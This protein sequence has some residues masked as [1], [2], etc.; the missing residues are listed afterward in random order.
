V[1]PFDSMYISRGGLGNLAGN[2]QKLILSL[3]ERGKFCSR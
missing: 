2:E 3:R 1:F